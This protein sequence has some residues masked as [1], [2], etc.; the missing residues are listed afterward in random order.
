MNFLHGSLVSRNFRKVAA[1]EN[2]TKTQ[3]SAEEETQR[4]AGDHFSEA[5]EDRTGPDRTEQQSHT[6]VTMT[7]FSTIYKLSLVAL[8]CLQQGN[9]STVVN[10]GATSVDTATW[11]NLAVLGTFY[12]RG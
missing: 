8:L 1:G 3:P 10:G 6:T 12:I 5:P 2:E 9:S 7:E 11:Y 4:A